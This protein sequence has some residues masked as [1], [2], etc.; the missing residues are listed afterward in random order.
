M[1]FFEMIYED[2]NIEWFVLFAANGKA[3]KISN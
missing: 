2:E 1:F 3:V